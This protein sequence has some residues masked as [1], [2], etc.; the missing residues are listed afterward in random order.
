MFFIDQLPTWKFRR[1]GVGWRVRRACWGWYLILQLMHYTGHGGDMPS[2][3]SDGRWNKGNDR[4]DCFSH[5][6]RRVYVLGQ[7]PLS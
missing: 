7:V 6:M 2:T 4:E 3:Q 1:E 5:A